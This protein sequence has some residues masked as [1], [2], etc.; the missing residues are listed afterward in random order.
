MRSV[1]ELDNLQKE[2]QSK[3]EKQAEQAQL[4]IGMGTCGISAGAKDILTALETELEERE[5][6]VIVKKTGCIGLCEKEPL[7]DVK[8]PGETRVTYGNLSVEDA[9]RLISEHLENGNIVRDLVV[10]KMEE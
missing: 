6:E 1:A 2:V 4:I 9:R 7:V 3:L 8:L 5:L 10:A